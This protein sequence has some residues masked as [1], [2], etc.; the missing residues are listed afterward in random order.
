MFSGTWRGLNIIR[1]FTL[2]VLLASTDVIVKALDEHMIDSKENTDS[3][4]IASFCSG[5]V[6]IFSLIVISGVEILNL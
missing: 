3:N 5:N 2:Y 1:L 6:V 4:L